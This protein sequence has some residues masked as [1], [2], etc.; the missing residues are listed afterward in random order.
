[1]SVVLVD[2][3][4]GRKKRANLVPRT[5]ASAPRDA[6]R[7]TA[8]TPPNAPEQA[9][10]HPLAAALPGL[11]KGER[12]RGVVRVEADRLAVRQVDAVVRGAPC[13]PWLRS[14]GEE[15]EGLDLAPAR[16][17]TKASAPGCLPPAHES[18][19]RQPPSPPRARGIRGGS[20]DDAAS[21]IV[22]RR[23]VRYPLCQTLLWCGLGAD[24]LR[25]SASLSGPRSVLSSLKC[26]R[27]AC[28]A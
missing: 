2:T 19:D 26:L 16:P 1:M 6:G 28:R 14:I 25:P 23:L 7:P 10:S 24:V 22:D 11:Q 18:D 9:K 4:I 17:T 12:Q 15:I 13:S 21:G 5:A 27:P 3:H 20:A 8:Q